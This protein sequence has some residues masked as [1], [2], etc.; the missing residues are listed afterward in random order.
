MS[1]EPE[2]PLQMLRRLR[3]MTQEQLGKEIGVTGNTIAR[4]ERGET[5]PRLTPEQTKK[6]CK[7]LNISLEELPNDFASRHSES[8]ASLLASES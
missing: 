2:S 7:A 4:W 6:L 5:Q 3:F 1:N 8:S